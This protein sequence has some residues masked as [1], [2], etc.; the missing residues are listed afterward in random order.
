MGYRQILNLSL[1]PTILFAL[2]S[3]LSIVLT[4]HYWILTDYIV[5]RWVKRR[6]QFPEKN[7]YQWDDVIIDYTESSTNATIVSGCLCLAAA[8]NCIVAYFKLKPVAMDL[9][10]HLV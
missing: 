3:F 9:D 2:L 5:G 7:K 6:S 1:A 10:Y 4:S 8:V